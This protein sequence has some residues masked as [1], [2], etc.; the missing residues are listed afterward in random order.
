MEGQHPSCFVWASTSFQA[1]QEISWHPT[2][3]YLGF[4][5]LSVSSKGGNKI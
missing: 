2:A 1:L 4:F 5:F 3:A